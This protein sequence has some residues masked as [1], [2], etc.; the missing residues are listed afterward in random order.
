MTP[1]T[2]FQPK[3]QNIYTIFMDNIINFAI[4]LVS[5]KTESN[6]A[7]Y[8]FSYE[9]KKNHTMEN[10]VVIKLIQNRIYQYTI[11]SVLYAIIY[12]GCI[13]IQLTLNNTIVEH[14]NLVAGIVHQ[15][16]QVISNKMKE[17]MI[18]THSLINAQPQ[19]S[20]EQN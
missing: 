16:S 11:L 1:K 8:I 20:L 14:R 4:L 9:R 7:K 10:I 6:Y 17:V 18:T 13:L 5:C 2:N 12:E 19:N 3:S 15:T